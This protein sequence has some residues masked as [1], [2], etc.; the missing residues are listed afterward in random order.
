MSE[1]IAHCKVFLACFSRTYQNSENCMFELTNASSINKPIVTILM[2]NDHLSW[3]NSVCQEICRFTDMMYLDLS[4][5]VGLQDWTADE[6]P[7][8][9]TMSL[10]RDKLT[11]LRRLLDNLHCSPSLPSPAATQQ[12]V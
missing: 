11:A 4:D 9:N 7:S 5:L 10:L 6:G 12:E 8:M 2:E 1:G 3:A